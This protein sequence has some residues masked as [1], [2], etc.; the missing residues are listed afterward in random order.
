[1][2]SHLRLLFEEKLLW[3]SSLNEDDEDR[4]IECMPN[5]TIFHSYTVP[6]VY[7]RLDHRT[8]PPKVQSCPCPTIS[9]Y[10]AF[11]PHQEHHS[12]KPDDVHYRY[13][14]Y[15]FRRY[16]FYLITNN[17]AFPM[18]PRPLTSITALPL[19]LEEFTDGT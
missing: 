10:N 3:D 11:L 9:I 12:P 7:G 2:A 5:A 6:T 17:D 18:E 15:N 14:G 16:Q 8:V 19:C 4:Y 13:P 1:M